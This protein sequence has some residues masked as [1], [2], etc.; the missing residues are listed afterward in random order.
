MDYI[1]NE[2]NYEFKDLNYEFELCQV[3]NSDKIRMNR[4][5]NLFAVN[6]EHERHRL[7]AGFYN[8]NSW[9]SGGAN[10]RRDHAQLHPYRS[11]LHAEQVAIMSARC[12]IAGSTLY[13]CRLSSDSKTK[14]MSLPCFFCMHQLITANVSKVVYTEEDNV[15]AFKI[16]TVK[17]ESMKTLHQ[18]SPEFKYVC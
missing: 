15:K 6:S 14:E 17:I 9:L 4:C 12:D 18:I 11:S 1:F 16:S 10:E 5:A 3:F 8:S 13:V 7:G 2:I